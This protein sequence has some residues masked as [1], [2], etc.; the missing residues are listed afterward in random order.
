[1][2]AYIYNNI[3]YTIRIVKQILSNIKYWVKENEQ[4]QYMDW[5]IYA[6]YSIHYYSFFFHR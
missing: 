6:K 4:M 5:K 3:I 1:M 2:Y